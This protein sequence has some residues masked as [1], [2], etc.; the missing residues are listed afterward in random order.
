MY[1]NKVRY[2][3]YGLMLCT[4]M[5]ITN[6]IHAQS[7]IFTLGSASNVA[8]STVVVPV[9]ASNFTQVLAWQG[10]INWN[11]S[12]LVFQSTSTTVAALAGIQFNASVNGN[13]GRLSFLWLDNGLVPQTIPSNTVLFTI[14][15]NVV[16]GAT[17]YSDIMF[18]N[19]PT[20]LLVSNPSGL[21]VGNVVY[22]NGSISF[23]GIPL[24]PEFSI[25]S[26][27]NVMAATVTVPVTTKNF[28]QLL[29]WQGSINWDNSKL[30]FQS[31][32]TPISQLAGMQF[33]NAVNGNTGQLSFL[34]I[35][36][37]VSP[38]TIA[39]NSVLFSITFNVVSGATG[40]SE[41]AFANAP[42]PLVVSGADGITV[43]NAVYNVGMVSFPG[44][45]MA[46]EF[47]VGSLFNISAST[48]AVPVTAKNFVQLLGWQG[49]LNW[50]NSKVVLQSISTPITQLTGMILNANVTGN[51]G[52]IS[53]L[54]TDNNLVPQTIADTTVLF[55]IYFNV[56][57]GT[58]GLVD[59]NFANAP[60]TL[61]VYNSSIN[62]VSNVVYTKGVLTF[63][64]DVCNG[65]NTSVTSEITGASYQWQLNTGNGFS[66]LSNNANYAGTTTI[67]L[68]FN[69]ISSA[70][71][72]YQYR[73][74]I[75]GFASNIFTL[76]FRN[77]F[78]GAVNTAWENTA[79]WSCGILPDDKTDVVINAG[80]LKL[81]T[82]A[83]C[84]S[85]TVNN[86]ATFRVAA[87]FILNLVGQ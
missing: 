22:N 57:A 18:T 68:S 56:V 31:I 8:T 58:T 59:I 55:T 26:S 66:N 80:Q 4:M 43:N 32:S 73:C 21:P 60:T 24:Q 48:V 40:F 12:K 50:D 53:F 61:A 38:Q 74:L 54:W 85:I 52:S 81:N 51:T 9:T 62:L 16:P 1:K 37:N 87:G 23:P 49:S 70:F 6:S 79:N 71:S 64:S 82:N 34:W 76:K 42:T 36:A 20:D 41:V 78:T 77:Y 35:D 7:P 15:F 11:N 47:T 19:N 30:V 75:N 45:I 84:K 69:S 72:G 2:I 10:S 28:I 83:T 39:D 13:M 14:T 44:T 46:P 5:F 29:G 65:G 17:G 3:F 86:G 67:T 33:S 27:S 25:G 63:S